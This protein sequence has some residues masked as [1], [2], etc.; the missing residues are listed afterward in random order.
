MPGKRCWWLVGHPPFWAAHKLPGCPQSVAAGPARDGEG[1]SL[2]SFYDLASDTT[3]NYSGYTLALPRWLSGKELTCQCR[4][5]RFDPWV[6]KI[7][8]RRKRKLVQ[9]SCLENPMDREAWWPTVH[10]VAKSWTDQ[11]TEHT[12]TH[13]DVIR[14]AGQHKSVNWE[15]G[16]P[17][18]YH[19]TEMGG[20][21]NLPSGKGLPKAVLGGEC[22]WPSGEEPY[23][24][25]FAI[26]ICDCFH[27]GR[28]QESSGCLT[29]TARQCKKGIVCPSCIQLPE[30]KSR[31]TC[32]ALAPAGSNH[33]G[34][35][36]SCD[37]YAPL[38][39]KQTCLFVSQRAG[40]QGTVSVN[41]C[42]LPS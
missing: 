32:L 35:C 26:S 42:F 12:P 9:Y 6:R 4:R 11:A 19:T 23:Y 34:V 28:I 40:K 2:R 15:V 38:L 39:A 13:V 30:K 37:T 3:L 20:R 8:W 29:G 17:G 16:G 33:P 14:M 31:T 5:H 21:E 7:P 1:R 27:L 10:G 36:H 25:C 18:S 24:L 41:F 22:F